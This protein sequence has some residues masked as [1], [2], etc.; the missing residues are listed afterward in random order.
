MKR[1]L[2]FF[3]W[4]LIGF[5]AGTP[6]AHAQQSTPTVDLPCPA[7]YSPINTMVTRNSAN[8]H[9][10]YNFCYNDAGVL[11]PAGGGGGGGTPGG[12][13]TQLQF[14]NGGMFG[15]M[16]DFTFGSHT[17][18]AATT[19]LLDLSAATAT[20]A[21]KVP[22]SATAAPTAN[23]AIAFDSAS[24]E[25]SVGIGGSS[26]F[27]PAVSGNPNGGDCPEWV[28][29][30]SGVRIGDLG[31]PCPTIS[32]QLS[33]FFPL[34]SGANA[35]TGHAHC[36]DGVS[37]ASTVTCSENVAA[38]QVQTTGGGVGTWQ[39]NQG[40]GTLPG[41]PSAGLINETGPATVITPYEHVR[42]AAPATGVYHATNA[43]GVMT[44]TISPVSLAA[45]VSGI[46]PNTSVAQT[47][48]PT[49]GTSVTLVGPREYYA[50][51]GNCTIT[52]PVPAFGYEFCV[53][54][55]DNV[56]ATITLAA[57]G[58]SAMYENTSRTAYGTAGTGTLSVTSATA[59]KVCIVGRDSTHYWTLS[60]NG[61]WTAS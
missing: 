38:P 58:S 52:V 53:F 9:L 50:C 39:I 13:D 46:L 55:D 45:D 43:T 47:P 42:V 41:V 31:I 54:T 33:G 40:N 32:G 5:A 24:G 51:T 2:K 11:Y 49:P 15:G 48:V 18:T 61:T 34:A 29:V 10:L 4:F 56:T 37:T 36:D 59:N 21:F 12:S 3:L 1:A 7:G 8:G 19:A 28:T 14:N 44:D 27:L 60:F 6:L 17:I 20:N 16:L 22:V 35:M 26:T 23:G 30:G 25:Y 57:L